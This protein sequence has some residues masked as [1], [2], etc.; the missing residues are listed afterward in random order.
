MTLDWR[1]DGADWPNR[2]A[3]HF[4]EAGGV[5]FHV[6]ILGAGPPLLLLHGTGGATHGWADLAPALSHQF[7]VLAPDL[8][9]HGFS[10]P[11]PGLAT[12]PA[13]AEVVA[14]LC[15]R[16][17]VAPRLL[18]GHSAGA[19]IAVRMTLDGRAAPAG[20]VALNGAL[21][22]FPGAA[23]ELF[24]GL[25]RLLFLNPLTPHLLAWQAN[26]TD[27]GRFLARATGSRLPPQR[28]RLYGR[29]FRSPRHVAAA[30]EMMANWDLAALR[31]DLPRLAV[32]LLL[33][34]GSNDLAVPASTARE[35]AR[36]VPKARVHVMSGLGH[37]AHEEAPDETAG[38]ILDFAR[39]VM[40]ELAQDIPA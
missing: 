6:Q 2:T 38:I 32:P 21:L 37:L 39:E 25:A 13:M 11:L 33:V 35:V 26:L 7:T 34:A 9:G 17:E 36:L 30:L 16:V 19:A 3:S 23:A 14:A 31:R 27:P 4:V 28:T 12:L 29:L 15:D 5:R 18:V 8:P 22:P 20:I 1:S 10:T 24:P 40:P